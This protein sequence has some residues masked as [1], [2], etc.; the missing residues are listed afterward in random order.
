MI[1]DVDILYTMLKDVSRNTRLIYP[2]YKAYYK[3][4]DS[5]HKEYPHYH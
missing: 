5:T 3:G 2:V 1:K 4:R